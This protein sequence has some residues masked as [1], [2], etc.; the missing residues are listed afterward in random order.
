MEDGVK[1]VRKDGW[2]D[3]LAAAFCGVGADN[4]IRP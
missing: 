4:I 2:Q 1:R 3:R